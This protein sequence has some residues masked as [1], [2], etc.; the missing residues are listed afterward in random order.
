[1]IRLE[2]LSLNHK[3]IVYLVVPQSPRRA[4]TNH[5]VRWFLLCMVRLYFASLKQGRKTF[6]LAQKQ[7]ACFCILAQEWLYRKL[8]GTIKQALTKKIHS[9][10]Q[11]NWD[12]HHIMRSLHQPKQ[13]LDGIHYGQKTWLWSST[14]CFSWWESDHYIT[15]QYRVLKAHLFR[16][17]VFMYP[18]SVKQE[19]YS[20]G[21]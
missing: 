12:V 18:V 19:S 6:C 15:W 2:W 21:I 13:V 11:S 14:S 17:V 16:C 7:Q 9:T 1:M 10:L 8:T 4:R 5:Y 3:I 20:A